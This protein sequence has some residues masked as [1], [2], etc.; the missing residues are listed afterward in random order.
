VQDSTI[1]TSNRALWANL[2]DR[3]SERRN[4]KNSRKKDFLTNL[5]E[6]VLSGFSHTLSP[7][8]VL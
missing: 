8:T 5:F 6:N 1:G 7:L 3:F 2:A 4:F